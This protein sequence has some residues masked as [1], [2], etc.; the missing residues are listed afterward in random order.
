[1]HF[2][3]SNG[4]LSE[5]LPLPNPLDG[6]E[7]KGS[8][9]YSVYILRCSDGSLYIGHTKNLGVRVKEHNDGRGAAYTFKRRPVSL[10]YSE[11][12]H[13]EAKRDGEPLLACKLSELRP[14]AK[15]FRLR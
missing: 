6:D 8:A 13:S 10:V 14:S 15:A 4:A 1:M 3:E 9:M 2:S 5:E 7:S 12:F 11:T